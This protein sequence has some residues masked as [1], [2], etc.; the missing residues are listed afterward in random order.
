MKDIQEIIT[1]NLLDKNE[2]LNL[3]GLGMKEI[4]RSVF[5]LKHLK[6]LKLMTNQIKEIPEDILKLTNLTH[7]YLY[8]NRIKK[9]PKEILKEMPSLVCLDLGENNV[10]YA[11][12]L[13]VYDE[14]EKN[15]S[16]GKFINRIEGIKHE[17]DY[18]FFHGVV[19]RIPKELFD[20]KN[21]KQLSISGGYI[22]ALPKEIE[23]LDGLLSLNLDG[24]N[25]S[26]LPEEIYSL[27]NLE[28][29]YLD[30][31]SFVE[32][33]AKLL[34]MPKLRKISFNYNDIT[35]IR[36]FMDRVVK[37][38]SYTYFSFGANPLK[39]FK[40]DLFHGGL[41]YIREYV[42]GIEQAEKSES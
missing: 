34:D 41:D 12:I 23:K 36:K 4:P 3:S 13:E 30:N 26:T 15:T 10:N 42:Y 28:E 27:T 11:D 17:D 2:I 33:P 31:N 16:F 6:E 14:L 38:D 9:I 24:N 20:Y 21:L 39:D 18:L 22:D 25:L 8:Q 7:L 32:F 19:N 35:H 37:D 5:D 40:E 29:L 1:A